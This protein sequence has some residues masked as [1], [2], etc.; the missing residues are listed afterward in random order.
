MSA[1]VGSKLTLLREPVLTTGGEEL[2]AALR[3]ALAWLQANQEEINDLNVFPVP[4]GDTGSNM[5]LTLRSAVEE[6]QDDVEDYGEQEAD[7]LHNLMFELGCACNP[8]RGDLR[9]KEDWSKAPVRFA[10]LSNV[11]DEAFQKEGERERFE[12]FGSKMLVKECTHLLQI[13][14][15]KGFEYR[16]FMGEK[17]IERANRGLSPYRYSICCGIVIANVCKDLLCGIQNFLNSL[18]PSCLLWLSS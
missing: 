4:D 6:A 10:Q 8:F 17:L 2:L 11:V 12:G 9:G 15:D 16:L 13:A 5:Y 3:N 1:E 7:A 14:E 18:L